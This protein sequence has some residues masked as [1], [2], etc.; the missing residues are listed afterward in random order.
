MREKNADAISTSVAVNAVCE[1]DGRSSLMPRVHL[2]RDAGEGPVV[3]D[4]A[5]SHDST[6]ARAESG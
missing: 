2:D 6:E 4:S 5:T 3:G 1:C